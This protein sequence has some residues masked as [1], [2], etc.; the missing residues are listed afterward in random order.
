MAGTWKG[1]LR[2]PF[3]FSPFGGLVGVAEQ[4]H[5]V[6]DLVGQN[7]DLAPDQALGDV[8]SVRWGHCAR[9]GGTRS[10]ASRGAAGNERCAPCPL[11][12]PKTPVKLI[13]TAPTRLV[14]EVVLLV[15]LEEA[16][17]GMEIIGVSLP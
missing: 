8:R 4:P 7:D 1:Q 9:I 3:G 10:V 16:Y 11:A 12:T 14:D 17:A 15:V 6:G 2:S 13:E 5:P